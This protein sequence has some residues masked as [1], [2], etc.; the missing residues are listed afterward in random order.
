MSAIERMIF[1]KFFVGINGQLFYDCILYQFNYKIDNHQL[2]FSPMS[3]LI[4]KSDGK[5]VIMQAC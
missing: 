1:L 5:L 3:L 4:N 2:G